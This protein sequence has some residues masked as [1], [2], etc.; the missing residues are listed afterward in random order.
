MS[1]RNEVIKFNGLDMNIKLF[2]GSNLNQVGKQ[3]AIDNLAQSVGESLINTIIDDEVRRFRYLIENGNIVFNFFFY[4]NGYHYNTFTAADF[5]NDE[6]LSINNK[7]LNSFYI[8][9]FYDTYDTYT[10]TKIFTTYLTKILNGIVEEGKPKY[11]MRYGYDLNQLYFW[12]IPQSFINQ[13]TGSTVTAYVKFSFFNAKTGKIALFYNK[14][15]DDDT[16][17]RKTPEKMYFKVRLDLINQ[18]WEILTPSFNLNNNINAFE[19]PPSTYVDRVN[20]TVDK[21]DDKQQNYPSGS[22]FNSKFGNYSAI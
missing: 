8:L 14:D 6:I 18:T 22:T 11:N 10:Q 3:Q 16:I 2:L 1:I 7:I 20:D 4:K 5:T 13:Q 9:D 12:N 15:N 17:I 19:L 21:F